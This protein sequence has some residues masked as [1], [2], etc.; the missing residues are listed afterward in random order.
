MNRVIRSRAFHL[1]TYKRLQRVEVPACACSPR[2]EAGRVDSPETLE[3]EIDQLFIL[4]ILVEINLDFWR[5]KPRIKA[6]HFY[7][8]VL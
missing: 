8:F 1:T 5:L 7:I 2:C 3:S 6:F 4:I